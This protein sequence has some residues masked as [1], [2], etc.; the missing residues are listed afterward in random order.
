[1]VVF[2]GAPGRVADRHYERPV[3]GLTNERPL[4]LPWTAPLQR[5]RNVPIRDSNGPTA[6]YILA[7]T[8]WLLLANNGH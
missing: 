7:F 3:S 6:S 8:E 1:M 2:S 5:H 4:L